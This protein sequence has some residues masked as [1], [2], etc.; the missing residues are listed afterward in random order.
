MLFSMKAVMTDSV[1]LVVRRYLQPPPRF[2][3]LLRTLAQRF[4]LDIYLCRQSL[5]GR[6]LAVLTRGTRESLGEVSTVLRQY[7][8]EHWLVAGQL[9]AMKPQRI[10]ALQVSD[11]KIVFDCRKEQVSF[12]AHG[13]VLAV[14]ADAS[15]QFADRLLT[16]VVSS[17]AYLG[18]DATRDLTQEDLV[19]LILQQ[20]PVLDLYRLD[21]QGGIVAAVRIFPGRFHP[22]GLGAEATLSSRE[23]LLRLLDL[24]R[25]QAAEFRLCTGFGLDSLPG[26]QVRR[27]AKGDN[28]GLKRNLDA[29]TRY[30]GLMA[31]LWRAAPVVPAAAKTLHAVPSPLAPLVATAAILDAASRSGEDNPLSSLAAEM[32]ETA[33]REPPPDQTRRPEADLPLPPP[34]QSGGWSRGRI[35]SLAVFGGAVL[36]VFGLLAAEKNALLERAMYHLFASGAGVFAVALVFLWLAFSRLRLKRKIENTPTSRIRSLAMGMVEVKGRARR[37]YALVSPMSHLPCVFYRLTRYRRDKNERWRVTSVTASDHVPFLL[38]DDTGRVEVDP[39][40]ARVRAGTRQEG[41]PGQM[42]MSR[43]AS[44]HTE[45]WVEETIVE[46][47]QLYILG[48]AASKKEGQPTVRQ[49]VRQALRALK[50]NPDRLRTFDADGDGHISAAEW[51]RARAATEE[52]VLRQSLAAPA[53]RKRQEEHILIGKHKGRPLI[54]AETH[55]ETQLTGRYRNEGVILLILSAGATGLAIYLLLHYMT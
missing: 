30:G 42:A 46:G 5:T 2:D 55:C 8:V 11:E 24:V 17:T 44:D 33:T 19:K 27:A 49:K 1:L 39:R 37:R 14:L 9:T 36:S 50:Q 7:K 32:V 48:F 52:E 45:K 54:I 10:F 3:A 31:E 16:R 23:N 34:P 21:E 26:S 51:D 41:A 6:G 28:E 29:L 18:R 38:E 47:T 13:R 12:A 15:G 43:L 40:Q 53:H 22:A 25:G 35:W 4:A 20:M